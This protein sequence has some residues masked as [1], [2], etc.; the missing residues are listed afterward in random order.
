MLFLLCKNGNENDWK[1]NSEIF[2][3]LFMLF[4]GV[5]MIYADRSDMNIIVV[6][7]CILDV[8]GH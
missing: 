7:C 1:G 8:C 6:L 2:M 4:F 3:T 5:A